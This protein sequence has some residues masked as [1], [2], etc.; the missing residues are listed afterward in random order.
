[1]RRFIQLCEIARTN[2]IIGLAPGST[3]NRKIKFDSN[4]QEWLEKSQ[5]IVFTSDE[6]VI[7]NE[8]PYK[9][10]WGII[11][12]HI[13]APF[14]HFSIEKL[15]GPLLLATES[16]INDEFTILCVAVKE[17]G[18]RKF[19]FLSLMQRTNNN[20]LRV[21]ASNS[22]GG[23]VNKFVGM[24]NTQKVGLESVRAS[25]KIGTS[26]NKKIRRIRKVIYVS[27]KRDVA[28]LSETHKS[29]DWTHR[30]LVR[31]HWRTI[32]EKKLGKNREGEYSVVGFT[33][34]TEFEKGPEDAPLI[35][36]VR[37]IE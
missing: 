19:L 26:A 36:K 24:L 5:P 28:K 33:W 9:N 6:T 11:E 8:V 17:V 29:I 22:E 2:G 10:T 31:G 14:A 30:W 7:D 37:V 27:P 35:S 16:K 15:D 32:P 13:D 20:E 3:K 25:V 34:V 4:I 12:G 1:M 23:L 18:P 21:C